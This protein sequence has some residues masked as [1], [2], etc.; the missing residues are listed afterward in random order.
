MTIKKAQV[1]TEFLVMNGI[2]LTILLLFS[3]VII[4]NINQLSV[5]RENLI[6]KQALDQIYTYGYTAYIQGDKAEV[7]ATIQ[8]PSEYNLTFTSGNPSQ[9]VMTMPSGTQLV[10]E[11]DYSITFKQLPNQTGLVELEFK[12]KKGTVEVDVK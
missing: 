4:S 6:G 10:K 3:A 12:D 1:S 8:F 11:F 2:L 7:E 5:Q 9:L